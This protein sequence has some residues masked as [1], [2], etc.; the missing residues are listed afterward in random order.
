MLYSTCI[1]MIASSKIGLVDLYADMY[2][3]YI[4]AALPM[5]EVTQ[6]YFI[7]QYKKKHV[8]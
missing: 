7:L 6:C 2:P 3:Q 4:V 8:E 5:T 1:R